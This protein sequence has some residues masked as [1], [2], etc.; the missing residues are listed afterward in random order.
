MSYEVVQEV[1]NRAFSD[2][3]FRQQL[4]SDPDT[5]LNEYDLSPDEC[6]ALKA[7]RA[8][9]TDAVAELLD[10]RLSKRPAWLFWL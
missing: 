4:Y 7:I 10:R 8:E 2:D 9:E 5:A 1:L 6:A 3:A